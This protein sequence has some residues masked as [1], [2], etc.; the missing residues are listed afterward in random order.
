MITHRRRRVPGGEVEYGVLPPH[1]P[2]GFTSTTIGGSIGVTFSGHRRPAR[3]YLGAPVV[4]TDI[5][6]GAAFSTPVRDLAW[7]RVREPAEYLE[8]RPA[9]ATVRAFPACL[10]AGVRCG[11][12]GPA[13][14]VT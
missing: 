7:L 6:A 14:G 12:E 4:E 13:W 8:Y 2:E 1:A 5:P 10:P 11:P 9:P 3:Q